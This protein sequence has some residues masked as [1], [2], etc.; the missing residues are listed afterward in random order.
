MGGVYDKGKVLL[1]NP[2]ITD[3][4]AYDFWLK[5]LGLLYVGACLRARGYSV[6]LFDCMDRLHAAVPVG[7]IK[8]RPDGTGKFFKE[9]IPKPNAVAHVPRRYGRYGIP[10]DAVIKNFK[11]YPVPDV[12]L[13]TSGMTYWYTGVWEMIELL[14][15][16]FPGI[17]VVLGGIYATLCTNHAKEGSGADFV[18]SGS[19]ENPALK[20]V[21]EITG[22]NSELCFNGSPDSL[23]SPAYDLYQ[24]LESAAVLSSRGCPYSC[25]FCA[26][27]LLEPVYSRRDPA[28]VAGEIEKLVRE[29]GVSHIAFYD[30]ALLLSKD[31]YII[32][33]LNYIIRKNIRIKFHTPNGLH[34]RELERDTASL[35]KKAGFS[36]IRLSYE[37]SDLFWQQ[38]M[39]KVSD[40]DLL[41]SVDAL[42]SAGFSGSQIGAY[43][44]MG[45]PGQKAAEVAESMVFILRQGIKVSL[46]AFSPIPGTEL[47][48]QMVSQGMI[49]RDVDPLLTNNSIFP[50]ADF[51][52]QRDEF[53]KLGTLAAEANA[54]INKGENPFSDAVWKKRINGFIK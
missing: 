29:S 50:T 46:A 15:K 41:N 49:E 10:K 14:H 11:K 22:N 26:S 12:I 48:S 20:L 24:K 6:S 39:N 27:K 3:F 34:A 21:D 5:P 16:M 42:L 44:M 33:L 38:R 37:T 8:K 7:R 2:W 17:P 25:P 40:F 1:V 13:V 31:D 51:S 36:T 54:M 53:I 45:L 23:P 47:F 28:R 9:I 18:I 35:M 4:V 30:D 52:M 43:V 32:P 19:G